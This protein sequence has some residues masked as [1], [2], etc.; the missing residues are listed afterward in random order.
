MLLVIFYASLLGNQLTVKETMRAGEGAIT[1]SRRRGTSRAG[2][3]I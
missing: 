2:K 1:T 3:K